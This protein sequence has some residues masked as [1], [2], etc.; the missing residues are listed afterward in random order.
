MHCCKAH[1]G[2]KAFVIANVFICMYFFVVTHM[3]QIELLTCICLLYF[4]YLPDPLICTIGDTHFNFSFS[5][6]P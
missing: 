3:L 5:D 6:I 2:K 1:L 4:L